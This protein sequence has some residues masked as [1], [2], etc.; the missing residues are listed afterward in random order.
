MF[1]GVYWDRGLGDTYFDWTT[2]GL[3]LDVASRFLLKAGETAWSWARTERDSNFWLVT[4]GNRDHAL[5]Q[6]DV[7]ADRMAVAS[8][9]VL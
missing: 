8:W 2:R 5:Y 9:T 6:V 3:A 7:W 1:F 4:F